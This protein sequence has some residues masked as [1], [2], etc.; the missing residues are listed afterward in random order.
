M[1]EIDGA[2]N[3][4]NLVASTENK[5]DLSIAPSIVQLNGSQDH[6][7]MATVIH[8]GEAVIIDN[9]KNKFTD[10][11]FGYWKKVPDKAII[12]PISS[13]GQK[14]PHSILIVGLNPYRQPDEKYQSFFQLVTDQVGKYISSVRAME[15]ERKRIDALMEIDRAKTIFFSNISHEFRTPL[16]L[17]LS[18]LDDSLQKSA[19][20]PQDIRHNIEVSQRNAR[21]LLKLVNTLLDFSR[22]EAGRMHARFEAIDIVKITKDIASNFDNAVQKAGI[23]FVVECDPVSEPVY[24]DSDMWE[25]IVLNLISNAFK[26]TLKGR[27]TVKLMRVG[28]KIEFSVSDTGVGIPHYEQEKIFERFHRIQNVKGRSQEG[29]GIGLS[30]VKELVNL[31]SGTIEVKSEEGKGSVFTVSIPLGTDHLPADK[32]AK[33]AVD[34]GFSDQSKAYT[35]EASRW[36]IDD[37]PGLL[38][39]NSDSRS[40][41]KHGVEKNDRYHVLLADDNADMRDYIRRLLNEKYE[42]TA[43]TNGEEA[44]KEAISNAPDIIIS[45]V[46]MPVIDGFTLVKKLKEIASTSQIPVMLIS[47][48]AGEEAIIEGLQTG[49]DDYLVKPFSSKELIS[50]IDSNLKIYETRLHSIK[51]L[52]S[53]FIQ[54][55]VA[56]CILRTPNLITELANEF[57]LKMLGKNEK[58]LLG[59]PIFEGMPELLGQG[60]KELME[61][62]MLTGNPY[63]GNEVVIEHLMSGVLKKGYFNFVYQPLHDLEGRIDGLM[64]IGNE[65]TDVVEARIKVELSER[66]YRQLIYGLPAAVYTCDNNGY[67]TLYNNEA[68]ALWGRK[69]VLGKDTWDQ[70]VKMFEPDGITPVIKEFAPT[71]LAL[72]KGQTTRDKEYIFERPDGTRRNVEPYP[73]PLRD[74]SGRIVGAL[75][76]MLD[77]TER[78]ISEGHVAKLAAIV[79][80]SDDA[81]IGKTLE[82]IITSWNFGAEKLF[83]YTAEEMIGQPVAK[84]IPPERMNEEP[85]ILDRISRGERINHF[86]TKRIRKNGEQIDI[87]LTISPVVDSKSNIIGASKIARDITQQKKLDNDLRESENRYKNMTRELEKRVKERTRELTEANQFLE[88]SNKELEQFAFVT[89]HD[90]QEPLRKI[91]TFAN[92]LHTKHKD[93]LDESGIA[94]I[95]KITSASKRMSK[96][97]YDLLN[98]SRLVSFEEN[99]E[100]T[101]LNEIVNN[102]RT[103]FEI[104]IQQ[105]DAQLNID[106]LPII[107]AIPLQMNQ[108][109]HNLISNALKF[110]VEEKKPVI[111]IHSKLLDPEDISMYPKLDPARNYYEIT[112]TDNGIGFDKI[113]SEKIFEIFQR[114]NDRTNFEGTGIGLALCNKIVLNHNGV[115]FAESEENKGSTFHV[116]LPARK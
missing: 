55:P 12:L 89:S 33:P 87:S 86:E 85:I 38:S 61:E 37:D 76:M 49:A 65:I 24:A 80:S 78:K 107:E 20:L 96:L 31:H 5:Q 2:N 25:K 7:N 92:L 88:R 21:R 59:K 50:R 100:K 1:Y 63:F 10:L 46:M 70:M 114:L 15:E 28:K 110:T 105:K 68:V 62:V 42:V 19:S 32:I 77:I 43:V 8:L 9:L 58:D 90:L 27:I 82:G 97:I 30:L 111:D 115:I 106:P 69:P 95:E 102:I 84:L 101:D 53:L 81:I 14:T 60:V 116:I 75:N 66:R 40:G 4:A 112:V 109:F 36:L 23:K 103:D 74:A 113:Y 44:L 29:T 91:Q 83:G 13:G 26:Y 67:I 47:A 18:P 72:T 3:T 41:K 16:T 108:L 35:Q 52:H 54:A 6:W 51:Q 17:M 56:I 34:E 45:D 11:P 22:I 99:F 94:Y 73:Q 48:R 71:T 98:F 39:D 79:A 64:I 57:C 93:L 104:V